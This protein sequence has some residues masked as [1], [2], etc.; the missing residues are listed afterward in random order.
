MKEKKER[1]YIDLFQ[2]SKTFWNLLACYRPF[3][4]LVIA[5]LVEISICNTQKLLAVYGIF[6]NLLESPKT[7]WT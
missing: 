5:N 2:R 3:R 6:Q 7:F 1:V 4:Q